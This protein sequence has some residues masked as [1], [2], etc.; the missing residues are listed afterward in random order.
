MMKLSTRSSYGLRAAI[1]LAGRFDEA[2][3][4]TA[5]LAEENAIPRRYLEQI[6][7]RLRRKGLVEAN[8]GPKGGYRLAQ[9]PTGITVGDIVRAVEGELE[10]VL[11][12]QP[13]HRSTDCR[14]A[15]HCLSRKLCHQLESTL[16]TVLDG[17][18]LADLAGIGPT[19]V[20][21]LLER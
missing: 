18:T 21:L 9:P 11:C 20:S 8:R 15:S 6:L 1:A 19:K 12:S 17:T 5:A 7:N 10:P 2:P 3:Q 13:E 14:T 4:T 16:L